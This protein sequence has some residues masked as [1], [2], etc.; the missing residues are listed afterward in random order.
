[1][2]S[3]PTRD[4]IQLELISFV[5]KNLDKLNGNECD[6]TGTKCQLWEGRDHRTYFIV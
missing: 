4:E 6:S 2:N 5:E 1:M 3:M